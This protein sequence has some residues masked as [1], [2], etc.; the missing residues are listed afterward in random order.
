MSDW[1]SSPEREKLNSFGGLGYYRTLK[2]AQQLEPEYEVTVWNREWKDKSTELGDAEAFYKYIFTNY[3]IIWLHQTDN[4][5]TFAWLRTM[6]TH[7]KKKLVMDCDDLFLEVD[8]GNPA[9]KKLGR[10]KL[11]RENKRAMFATNMSFCDALTVSTVPLKKR[12]HQHILDVHGVDMPI[13][14][15]PNCND[16]EDWKYEKVNGSGVVIGYSG[17]LSHNDDLDMVL[18]AIKTIMEKYPDVRFQLMGQMD[19]D[20]A[21]KVFGKWKQS[22]R[23]RILLM[24]ATKTQPEY[25]AY[26]A[27]QPWSIGIAP[28]IDSPFNECKSSIKFFEYSSYKIPVVASRIYPYHKDILGVPVIEHEETGLLCDTVE[29]WVTNLSR[30]IESEELRKKLGQNAYDHVVKNWQYKDWKDNIIKVVD[31]ISML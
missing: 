7:F 6:A 1:A 18:P 11:N 17:G 22:I 29:D 9:A 24:N 25:P 19:L 14:V 16:I 2:I 27:E 30:L 12:L 26:L 10:G 13:F 23:E 8:K 28:L 5:L 21:K 20:K 3:D 4:D 15:I 31:Q